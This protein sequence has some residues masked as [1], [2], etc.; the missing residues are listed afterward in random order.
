MAR[1]DNWL[2]HYDSSPVTDVDPNAP[3]RKETSDNG[4]TWEYARAMTGEHLKLDVA[5]ALHAGLPVEI[6]DDVVTFPSPH[7]TGGLVRYTPTR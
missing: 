6:R 1:P 4:A 3:Y 2:R 5:D 7:P